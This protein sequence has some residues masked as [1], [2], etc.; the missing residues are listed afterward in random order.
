M[1]TAILL[2]EGLE[3]CEALV[4]YDLLYRAGIDVKLVG[5]TRDIVSSHGERSK[6]S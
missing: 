3:E 1:N 4:T 5:L 2:A 6:R